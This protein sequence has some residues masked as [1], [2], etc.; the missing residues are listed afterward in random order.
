MKKF[1]K[2]IGEFLCFLGIHQFKKVGTIEF[3][4]GSFHS[5]EVCKR[6]ELNKNII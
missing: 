3:E 1:L 2:D 5:K 4:D 6:C